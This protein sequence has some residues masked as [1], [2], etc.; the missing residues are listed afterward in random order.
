MKN[1]RIINIDQNNIL[2]YSPTCFL[3]SENKGY[4]VKLKWLKKRFSE[5]MKIK[6][7]YLEEGGKAIGFIEYMPGEYAWRA[8]EAKEFMFIHCIWITPNKNKKKGY[9]SLLIKECLKDAK[10]E[11]KLGVVAVTSDSAFMADKNIFLKNGFKSIDKIKPFDL[12]VR[13]F[14]NKNVL[15]PR[16]KDTEKQLKKY[17]GLNIIYSNQCPWVSRFIS[18]IDEVVKEKKLKLKITELKTAKQAQ[19]APSIYSV[20]N[21]VYNG[22]LLADHYISMTRFRNIIEKELK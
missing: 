5:G 19:N 6:Q 10:K 2:E 13:V 11:N 8:I 15:L 18:E 4:Q 22:K 16:F 9:G 21:L 20:F 3:N 12:M 14:K 17:Q 7:L 1:I